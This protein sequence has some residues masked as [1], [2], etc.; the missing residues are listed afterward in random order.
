MCYVH[1][2]QSKL[3]RHGDDVVSFG[4]VPRLQWAR[5]PSRS[6]LCLKKINASVEAR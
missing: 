4:C 5:T 2:R 1:E 3:A 6:Y